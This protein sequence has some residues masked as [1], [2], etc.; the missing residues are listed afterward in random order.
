MSVAVRPEILLVQGTMSARD[1]VPLSK[2]IEINRGVLGRASRRFECWRLAED[3][4]E[5]A[6]RTACLRARLIVE[7]ELQES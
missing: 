6:P 1:L 2:W 7:P 3:V 5:E 4:E